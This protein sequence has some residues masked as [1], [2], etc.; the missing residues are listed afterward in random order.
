LVIRASNARQR[1]GHL[2]D[3]NNISLENKAITDT[4]YTRLVPRVILPEVELNI[5]AELIRALGHTDF[6]SRLPCLERL[7]ELPAELMIDTKYCIIVP[8]ASWGP[9]TWPVANFAELASKVSKA[10]GLKVVLCGT[11]SEKSICNQVAE[12]S[13][14]DV[15]N[16]AGLTSLAQM[17]EIIRHASL[18]VANDSASIHIAAATRTPCVCILGGGHFGRFL[19][20]RPEVMERDY[21]LPVA[22]FQLMDCYGCRWRCQYPLNSDDAVPCVS[23]VNVD[24]VLRGCNLLTIN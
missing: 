3:V 7:T 11:Q 8:G 24:Q 19:P 9:K 1:I 6:K 16:F 5:N 21:L 23:G 18:L 13:G 20:Y 10:R 2:G 22:V 17:I 14:V 15:I 12:L 4:W